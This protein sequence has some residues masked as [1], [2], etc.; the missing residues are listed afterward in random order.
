M[1]GGFLYWLPPS[2]SLRSSIKEY[3]FLRICSHLFAFILFFIQF[4][5]PVLSGAVV[6]SFNQ[7]SKGRST[8]GRTVGNGH[9]NN[10]NAKSNLNYALKRLGRNNPR[11]KHKTGRVGWGVPLMIKC[12]G[13][14]GGGVGLWGGSIPSVWTECGFS[15][16]LWDLSKVVLILGVK[17]MRVFILGNE[18]APG[19]LR[20]CCY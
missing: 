18:R 5:K 9:C 19:G 17:M 7:F 14:G 10:N 4:P 15:S 20:S 3:M 13:G 12:R 6:S 11:H 1:K 2:M 16:W 8:P